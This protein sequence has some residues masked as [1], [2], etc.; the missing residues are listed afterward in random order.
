MHQNFS[1]LPFTHTI[2]RQK[3][4]TS[5]KRHHQRAITSYSEA[6]T[7]RIL[8]SRVFFYCSA[9]RMPTVTPCRIVESI[10]SHRLSSRDTKDLP[11]HS[12]GYNA[13]ILWICSCREEILNNLLPGWLCR[14]HS[15][16]LCDF[17]PVHGGHHLLAVITNHTNCITTLASR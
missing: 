15:S 13:A 2:P 4:T 17:R 10:L 8:S 9:Y 14:N 1:E 16:V 7:C 12:T 5:S 3:N 11:D 6:Q